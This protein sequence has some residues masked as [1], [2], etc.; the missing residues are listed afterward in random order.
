MWA[1]AI[2]MAVFVVTRKP[3]HF[4]VIVGA[5]FA[6]RAL[7]AVMHAKRRQR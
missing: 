4:N 5:G 6:V 1:F 7:Q 3:L 2:G